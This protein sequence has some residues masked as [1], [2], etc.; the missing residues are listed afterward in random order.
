MGA[1]DVGGN[2]LRFGNGSFLRWSG[3]KGKANSAKEE[4]Q[5]VDWREEVVDYRLEIHNLLEKFNNV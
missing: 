5:Q 1:N 2:Q 4:V 3:F